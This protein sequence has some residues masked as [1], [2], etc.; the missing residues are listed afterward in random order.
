GGANQ[1]M[2]AG[3]ANNWLLGCHG[4]NM[5]RA[6]GTSGWV[7]QGGA[8]DYRTHLYEAVV[9]GSGTFTAYNNGVQIGSAGGMQGPNGVCLGATLYSGSQTEPSYGDIGEVLVFTNALSTADRQAMEQYLQAKWYGVISPANTV[10][11][12]S[13]VSV[14]DLNG[15]NQTIGSLYGVEGSQILLNGAWL[16]IG[17]NS[18]ASSYSGII[19]DGT[20]SGG[21]LIKVG[22]AQLTLCG[23]SSH[24][25]SGQFVHAQ[26]YVAL[27][28]TNATA[29][30]GDVVLLNSLSPTLWV[31]ADNQVGGVLSFANEVN[32]SVGNARFDLEGTFQ[33]LAG[34]VATDAY[35]NSVVQNSESSFG[36]PNNTGTGTLTLTGSGSYSF[37]GY[38]RNW[39][40]TLAVAK[41]GP[42]AQTLVGDRI[43]YTGATTVSGGTLMLHNATAFASPVNVVSGGTLVLTNNTTTQ[44]TYAKNLTGD[45]ACILAGNAFTSLQGQFYL[46]GTNTGFTGTFALAN[47]VRCNVISD[48]ALP[49]ATIQVPAG[50]QIFAQTATFN[51]SAEIAGNGWQETSG[52]IGA[53]R[54]YNNANWAGAITLTDD[55]RIAAWESSGTISG[56][57]GG[58]GDLEYWNGNASYQNVTIAGSANNTYAGD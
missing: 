55:G 14:L 26:G 48:S 2:F 44:W 40:G 22:S 21:G 11:L 46:T 16:T 10:N 1:R 15:V 20:N 52:Q 31:T 18:S 42:G 23:S 43:T 28:M 29:I 36:G 53:I 34:I 35:R 54:L 56:A 37:N 58:T 7:A 45:G 3:V 4:G 8:T 25:Y 6:Y 13:N 24:T 50:N 32:A 49:N 17:H 47:G 19:A 51:H 33:S 12:S 27:C 57:I 39:T 41:T 5:D 38:L 9:N 30:P